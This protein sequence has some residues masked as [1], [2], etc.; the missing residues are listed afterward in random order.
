MSIRKRLLFSDIAIVLIPFIALLLLEMILGLFLIYIIKMD[1][2]EGFQNIFRTFH[3]IGLPFILIATNGL[4]TYFVAKSVLRP[5]EKLSKA[6]EL[7]SAGDFDS[8]IQP[9]GNDEL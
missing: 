3:L 1:T 7:I 2:G 8:P 4:L 9:M 5:V 6:A